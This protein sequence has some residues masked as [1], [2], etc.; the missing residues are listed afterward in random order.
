MPDAVALAN[1]AGGL[2]VEKFGCVPIPRDEILGE[3]LLEQ[4]KSLGKVRSL[5]QLV[6][7]LVRRRARGEKV[8]LG[9]ILLERGVLDEEGVKRVLCTHI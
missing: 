7:E 3:I 4:H 2:E 5:G 8:L 6:P 9:Q 1:V